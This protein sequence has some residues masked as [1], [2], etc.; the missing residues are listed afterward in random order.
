[1]KAILNGGTIKTKN[2]RKR[3]NAIKYLCSP[4]EKNYK[5]TVVHTEQIIKGNKCSTA[6]TS[7]IFRSK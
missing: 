2:E 3:R 7:D 5:Y 1:M 4:S 6:C